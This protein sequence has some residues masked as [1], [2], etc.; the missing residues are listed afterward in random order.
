[1]CLK[2]TDYA[3]FTFVFPM[4]ALFEHEYTN[5]ERKINIV[6]VRKKYKSQ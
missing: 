5:V 2:S 4:I 3:F 6:D 1:M